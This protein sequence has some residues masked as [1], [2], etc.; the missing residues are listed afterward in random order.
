M[1]IVFFGDAIAEHLRRWTVFFAGLGHEVHVVTWNRETLPGYDTVCIHQLSK[2]VGGSGIFSR[3]IT[4]LR[5]RTEVRRLMRQIRPDLVHSHD[6][7]SYAWMGMFSGVRPFVITP[8]GSDIL[9]HIH[10]SLVTRLFTVWA[11]RRSSLV[12][13]EGEDTR[14]ALLRLGVAPRNIAVVPIGVDVRKFSPGKPALGFLES[15]GLVNS[16]I[17][18]STRTP[19]PV[20]D[21]ESTVRAAA[22]VLEKAPQV[23]FL[24]VG[25]GSEMQ[26]LQKLADSLGIG[27]SLIFTG[28]VA[29]EEMVAC[30]RAADVYVSTSLSNS[31]TPAST[32][33]AMACGLPVVT[34][35]AGNVR[36][37]IHDAENGYVVP[38]KDPA[39]VAESLLHILQNPEERELAGDR[40][41]RFVEEHINVDKVMKEMEA[42]YFQLRAKL[43]SKRG[44]Q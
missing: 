30:L 7:G 16:Q 6:A 31:G 36:D 10:E 14:Q 24:M 23:K 29:E 19:N 39:A 38:L 32:A 4:F 21:V 11:L 34:T 33:E 9:I 28:H 35:D 5:L 3:A 20:H 25:G 22:I 41:R 44:N 13:A 37:I 18:V 8:W 26:S 42:L 12:Q 40:N 27:R 2:P 43:A 1:K 17:V 15:R